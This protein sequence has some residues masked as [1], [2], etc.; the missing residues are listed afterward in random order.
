MRATIANLSAGGAMLTGVPDQLIG[1]VTGRAM[2]LR[3]DG[4]ARPLTARIKSSERDRLHVKFDLSEADQE[5]FDREVERLTR[6]LT[7]MAAVA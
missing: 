4:V 6:G 7:P 1:G 2:T 3:I 5:A